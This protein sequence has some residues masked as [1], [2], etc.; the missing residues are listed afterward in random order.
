MLNIQNNASLC[1][2]W[3]FLAVLALACSGLLSIIVIFLRLPFISSLI[4]SAQYI[5]DNALVIHVNLSIL[6]WMCSI[7][8]LLFIINLKNTNHWFNF[9]WILSILSMLL[10]FISAFV[11]NTEVIKSNYIPVLQNKLFLLGLSLFI[12]SILINTALAYIS[13]KQDSY[14]SIGQIG[15]VIILVSSFLCVVLAHKNMPPG[16]YHSDKN[17]FYEYL[18]WGGGHLLQFAFAQAM[19]LVYLIILNARYISLNKITILPLFINTVLTVGAPFIYFIYSADSAELIQFFT[20]HMRIAGAVLPCFLTILVY[21]N[22]KTLLNDKG[23]YLLHSFVLFIYG[24][25]LGVLTIEGNVT[26]PA[27]YHG[28]VVGITIAFMNFVYWLL[29]KLGCKEIKSSIVRLQIYAYSL[30]H[31]LHITG[32]VWLGGYGALRKVADL[33]SISSMLARACFITGGA[34]SVIGGMLFVIIVI[35]HL[36]KGKAR[37]N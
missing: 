25:V 35:L 30:G 13:N 10:M 36:L 15:L 11:P 20:W 8:S 17:L 37:T 23:N 16:L 4:P 5:F 22:I 33:P 18:F 9:S 2:Q 7:I 31:F 1:R 12:T 32:L 19:F 34:I 24:G 27:H 14:L 21:C 29:P 6:V 3:I 26:I 28:S